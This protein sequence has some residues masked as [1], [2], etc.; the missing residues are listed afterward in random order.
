MKNRIE[1]LKNKLRN[2]DNASFVSV[3]GKGGSVI[4]PDVREN[5][6]CTNHNDCTKDTNIASCTNL[7]KC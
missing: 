7:D 1:F 2:I 6:I 3:K 5:S 4:N